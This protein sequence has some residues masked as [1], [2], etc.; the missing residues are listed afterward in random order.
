MGSRGAAE[1]RR[2]KKNGSRSG[3]GAEN[4]KK[5]DEPLHLCAR[6]VSA[7]GPSLRRSGSARS[8]AFAQPP[9]Y[10][11]HWFMFFSFGRSTPQI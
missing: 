10:D 2:K 4:L 6:S 9:S 3:G 1:P 8:I 7:R 11:R 5:S